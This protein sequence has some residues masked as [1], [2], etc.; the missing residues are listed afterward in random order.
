MSAEAHTVAHMFESYELPRRDEISGLDEV[1]LVDA[2]AVAALM[3]SAALEVR[4]A[5]IE[6]MYARLRSSANTRPSPPS[7]E[8]ALRPPSNRR[9]RS[10]RKRKRRR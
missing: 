6:E 9:R 5:A 3:E 7:L 10:N 1:G 2:M 4:L 8:A